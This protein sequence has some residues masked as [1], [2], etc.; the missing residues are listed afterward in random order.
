M[1]VLAIEPGGSAAGRGLPMELAIV[2]EGPAPRQPP[3]GRRPV[4]TFPAALRLECRA[5][6]RAVH[7]APVGRFK[8]ESLF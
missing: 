5:R 3:D 4:R 8:L 6:G 2:L 7:S 1:Q